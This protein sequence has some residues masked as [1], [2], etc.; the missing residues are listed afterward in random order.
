M[1]LD[2]V[3]PRSGRDFKTR[4][5]VLTA[6]IF[7]QASRLLPRPLAYWIADRLGELVYLAFP[8]YRENVID[9]VSH[10]LGKAPSSRRVR[11]VARQAFRN[12]A[13]NF[14]DLLRVPSVSPEELRASVRWSDESRRRLDEVV[15]AGKGGVI[16]SAHYGAFDYVGQVLWAHGYD[17][18]VLTTRTVP[19]FIDTA[20]SHLRASRG[21]RLES[22]TP[23]GVRRVLSR[24]KR[25]ELIGLIA[26]RDFFQSGI[27]VTFFGRETT[28]P[29]GPVRM[30]R[31][32]GA[33]IVAAFARR[34]HHGYQ[35]SVEP[36]FHVEKT[37]DA[38][39]DVRRGLQRLVA[40]FERYL[41]E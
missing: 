3:R 15:A 28:L 6:W 5:S 11:R 19:E 22:A 17:L 30:A 26:D 39:A 23:G 33:P 10:V 4:L 36:P 29:P 20:V 7:H 35:L 14:V 25:G 37:A 38:E 1:T 31:D 12:S 8:T 27:P 18:T 40:I 32:T 9:N 34:L 41:R 21:A 13:R 2:R 16:V 24:L